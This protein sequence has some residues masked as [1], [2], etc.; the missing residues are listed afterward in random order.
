MNYRSIFLKVI[1]YLFF[2]FGCGICLQQAAVGRPYDGALVVAG[3][4][5]IHLL[6]CS[7]KFNEFLTVMLIA[8]IGTAIDTLFQASGFIQYAGNYAFAP[9]LA[10]IWITS[11]WVLLAMCLNSS[12]SWL[13][14]HWIWAAVLG[15]VGACLS[16]LA[17]AKLG[18]ARINTS[19]PV[20]FIIL[21]SVWIWLFPLTLW[22]A[23]KLK[24]KKSE[25]E[26][27]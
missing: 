9:W 12:L 18:A 16:Y 10:P 25:G 15:A 14:G 7:H 2:Y 21:G 17:G 8:L 24:F 23:S 22:I 13:H 1:N 27:L 19:L 3:L 11:I 5:T 6:T 20:A 4:F 26:F